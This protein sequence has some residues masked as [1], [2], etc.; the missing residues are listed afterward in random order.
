MSITSLCNVFLWDSF[1]GSAGWDARQRVAFFEYDGKFQSR[2]LELAPLMMPLA[3]TKVYSYPQLSEETFQGL[4]GLLADSLPDYFG[5]QVINAFLRAH[6]RSENS[7]NP[8]EKLCYMGK[9]GMGALEFRPALS[10][11]RKS[12]KIDVNALSQLA[13]E[14]LLKRESFHAS[15]SDRKNA[16]HDILQVGSSAGGARP[17]AVIAWNPLTNEVFSGQVDAP[18]GCDHWLLKFDMVKEGKS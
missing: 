11:I 17:K 16:F 3:G 13:A 12:Q 18:D 7:F 14:I 5:N 8:V 15:I 9:R 6:G 4:P 2:K 10:R 1:V